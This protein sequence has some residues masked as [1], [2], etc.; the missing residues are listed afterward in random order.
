VALGLLAAGGC[1]RGLTEINRNPNA[2]DRATAEQLFTNAVE[3]SVSRAM[4]SGLH[5]GLTALWAQHFAK[6]RYSEEDRYIVSDGT[7]STHWSSFYVGPQQDFQEVIEKG[8]AEGRANIAAMGTVMQSWTY[9][10]MTDLWG[11]IGYSEAL[12]GRD[13]NAGNLP[14]LDPQEQVYDGIMAALK[15]S[16]AR[17]NPQEWA[18]GK[19]DLIYGGNA[20]QWKK[21]TNSLRLRVAMRLSEVAPAKAQAEFADALAAGV[22]TSNADNAILGYDDKKPNVH[23]IFAYMEGRDDHSISATMVDTLTS[24]S[25]PRLPI[26]ATRSTRG[27]Y[28]GVRNG[29]TSDPVLDSISRIGTHFT[30]PNAEMVVMGYAEVLFLQAEAIERGWITGDAA[31]LYRQGI[32]ASLQEYGIAQAEIDAY[33]AQPQVAYAGMPSIGFQKWIAL[34]GNGVEAYAEWRRTGFPELTPG[35]D[36]DNN[37]VIPVRLPYPSSE[38]RRNGENLRAAK[39]RQGGAGLNDPLWW[40]K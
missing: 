2:A 31:E 10:V 37:G 38:E 16:Q 18:M 11:D 20:V 26:Y 24:L 34:F 15:A 3:A 27:E 8:E 1:D 6:H 14:A 23:P 9:H 29:S 40:N 22:F 12:R 36:A 32:A 19:A 5:M 13:P 30:R 7:I 21:F 17:F 25:D 33:L 35:P 39:A 4:G 28:V